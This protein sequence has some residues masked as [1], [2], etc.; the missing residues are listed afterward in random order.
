M[1]KDREDLRD[2]PQ[3]IRRLRKGRMGG[4][5][6]LAAAICAP[7][8]CSGCPPAE[9]PSPAASSEAANAEPPPQPR[10]DMR[11]EADVVFEGTVL[12]VEILPREIENGRSVVFPPPGT[13]LADAV[14]PRYLVKVQVE[15]V[16]KGEAAKDWTGERF[17]AI[18]SPSRD[19]LYSKDEA[20]GK[21]LVFRLFGQ[22]E[23]GGTVRFLYMRAEPLPAQP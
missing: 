18:H 17:L 20:P 11:E 13:I 5:F 12:S 1:W 9:Q 2:V 4:C 7:A 14:D 15:R 23:E 3:A 6:L 22:R 19:L 10:T 21:R 8:G 16:L